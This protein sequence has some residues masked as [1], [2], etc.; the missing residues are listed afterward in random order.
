MDMTIFNGLR[1]DQPQEVFFRCIQGQVIQRA[2]TAL[3]TALRQNLVHIQVTHIP[4][5][6]AIC[7]IHELEDADHLRLIMTLIS[8]PNWTWKVVLYCAWTPFVFHFL[9]YAGP[10]T[11][12]PQEHFI[13]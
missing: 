4:R 8:C 6:W 13:S 11:L 1:P 9:H 2:C 7:F 3:Q 12:H 5:R 10:S